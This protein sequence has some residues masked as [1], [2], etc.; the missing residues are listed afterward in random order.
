MAQSQRRA[1]DHLRISPLLFCDVLESI[2]CKFQINTEVL[3]AL[4][5]RKC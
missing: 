5:V 1:S 2:C 3:Q 4:V